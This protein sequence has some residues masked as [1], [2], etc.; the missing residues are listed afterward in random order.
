MSFSRADTP[1]PSRA[2][3]YNAIPYPEI[4]HVK[5]HIIVDH[6]D[7]HLEWLCVVYSNSS[8]QCAQHTGVLLA[9]EPQ[10]SCRRR[11]T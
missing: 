3:G 10:Q 2:S 1:R 5:F 6:A 11:E 7:G 9:G 8:S 4:V